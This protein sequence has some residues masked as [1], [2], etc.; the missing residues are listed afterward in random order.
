MP[1]NS[2]EILEFAKDCVARNDEI[3]Y[4]NGVARA[5]YGAY[6]HILPLMKY[7]PKD[8]HQGLIDY[9]MTVSWK[10]N[11]PYTKLELTG[12]GIALQALKDQRIISD[13]HL[14]ATVTANDSKTSIRTAEK[15]IEKWVKLSKP[16]AS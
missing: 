10:G 16:K 12:L 1:V 11:E 5:Y 15:L 14:N 7:G 9:L 4:R 3:G 2:F 8:S 13:Y 6:H